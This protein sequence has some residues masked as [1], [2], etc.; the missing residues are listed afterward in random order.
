V[1]YDDLL[2]NKIAAGNAGWPVQF[3]VAVD[4]GWSRVP[5]LW[6][7]GGIERMKKYFKIM[8]VVA[9]TNLLCFWISYGVLMAQWSHI[10]ALQLF[11]FL[12]APPP[13]HFAMF[14]QWAFIVLGA[15]SSLLLDGVSS[16]FFMPALILCSVLNSIVWGVCL[17]LPIYG[18]SKRFRH[19]AAS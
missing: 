16:A 8:S 5:E 2:P 12:P 19:V 18:V 14:V 4:A 11:G 10:S 17:A 15:P 3:R 1:R 13:S 9:V 7:L 6:T